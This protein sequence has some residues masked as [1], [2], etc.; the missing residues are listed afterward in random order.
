VKE[1]LLR[2]HDS[3][4]AYAAA[5]DLYK[6]M[7]TSLTL[8]HGVINERVHFRQVVLAGFTRLD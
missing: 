3:A 5:P 4:A 6:R 8:F 1:S 7:R 2:C